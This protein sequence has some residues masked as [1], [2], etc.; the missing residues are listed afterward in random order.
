MKRWVM[1]L[2]IVAIVGCASSPPE[3]TDDREYRQGDRLAR[4]VD[5][6][7]ACERAGGILLVSG[8]GRKPSERPESQQCVMPQPGLIP[9]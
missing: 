4:A 6:Q 5:Y 9:Y 2:G 8:N 1:L 3:A 7:I